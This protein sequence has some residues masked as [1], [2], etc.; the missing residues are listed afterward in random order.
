MSKVLSSLTILKTVRQSELVLAVS[1]T[2]LAMPVP[3]LAMYVT[4]LA[5]QCL[6][7]PVTGNICNLLAMCVTQS[8]ACKCT[9]K[10]VPQLAIYVTVLPML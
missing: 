7:L 5:M 8:N 1:V 10:S 6:Y 2:V 3:V 4:L 9:G